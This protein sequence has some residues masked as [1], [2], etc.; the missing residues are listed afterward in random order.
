MNKERYTRAFNRFLLDNPDIDIEDAE[1]EFNE[2]Y[3]NGIYAIDDDFDK[4][5]V[6]YEEASNTESLEECINLLHE[7]IATCPYHYD[8]KILLELISNDS[9]EERIKAL[10]N[11]REEYKKWLLSRGINLDGPLHSIWLDLEARPYI[12]LLSAVEV[13]LTGSLIRMQISVMNIL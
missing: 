8:S 13:A 6:L 7:A 12:R 9:S 5:E 10:E 1:K 3:N 2:L 11:I 4:A